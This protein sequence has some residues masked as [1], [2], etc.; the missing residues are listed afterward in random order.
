MSWYFL[1]LGWCGRSFDFGCSSLF[2]FLLLLVGCRSVVSID[3]VFLG[4]VCCGCGWRWSRSIG[5]LGGRGR[6]RVASSGTFGSSLC[7]LLL[8]QSQLDLLERRTFS[9]SFFSFSFSFLVRI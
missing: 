2:L 4:I 5:L 8:L 1:A 6:S 9:F 3:I 7:F